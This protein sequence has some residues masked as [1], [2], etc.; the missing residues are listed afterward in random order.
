[1]DGPSQEKRPKAMFLK[2][3]S[4][5]SRAPRVVRY[6]SIIESKLQEPCLI[7]YLNISV[8]CIVIHIKYLLLAT[9][10]LY[11]PSNQPIILNL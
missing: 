3:P 4:E 10:I 6:L 7:I 8:E 1:M 2:D 9:N 5:V 11:L